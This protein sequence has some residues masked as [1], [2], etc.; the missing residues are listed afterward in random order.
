MHS[1]CCF[2]NTPT[3]VPSSFRT[4]P[5]TPQKPALRMHDRG[6]RVQLKVMAG[7]RLPDPLP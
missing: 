4:T 1:E 5:P 3:T 6:V 2:V 7:R